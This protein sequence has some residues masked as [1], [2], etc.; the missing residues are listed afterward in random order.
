M[1]FVKPSAAF[2]ALEE[3]AEKYKAVIAEPRVP[4]ESRNAIGKLYI[5]LY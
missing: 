5:K 1:K 4:K 2:A 3:C